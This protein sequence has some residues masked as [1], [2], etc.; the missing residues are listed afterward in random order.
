MEDTE[1]LLDIIRDIDDSVMD[2]YEKHEVDILTLSSMFVARL[3]R[4][5]QEAECAEHFAK[6]C[7]EHVYIPKD[8]IGDTEGRLH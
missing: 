7:N 2:I 3:M 4:A 5:C 1:K 8:T 6:F